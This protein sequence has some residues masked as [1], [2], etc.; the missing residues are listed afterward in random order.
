L[1]GLADLFAKYY[2]FEQGSVDFPVIRLH[3]A[4]ADLAC[5]ALHAR[6]FA[7]GADIYFADGAFA[8]HTRAG[9]WLLAHEVAHVVQQSAGVVSDPGSPSALS[10]APA[11]TPE[12][13]AAAAAANAFLAGRSFRFAAAKP[14]HGHVRRRVVQRYMAWE[15]A[16]LGDLTVD[17]IQALTSTQSQ[18]IEAYCALLETLGRH[19]RSV[20]EE[21]LQSRY[22]G[23]QTVRLPGSGLVVTLGELNILPDYLG[24]PGEIETAPAAFLGPLIQ[25]VRSWSI[26]ELRRSAG[27][28]RRYRRLP[29]GLR[30]PLLGR[31]AESAEV[32]AVDALGKRCGFA[33]T[34]RYSSVLARNAA[35]FAPF[36]WYRWHSFHLMARALIEKSAAADAE[37]RENLR[38]RARI[39]AG[40]AD[41]FLQ[42][43]FAAGHLINKTLMMQWY[44][45]WLGESGVWNPDRDMLAAMTVAR[46]PMLHGS[47][48]YDRRYARLT[49]AAA[50]RPGAGPWPP[51]DP[52]DVADA[53]TLPDS[54]EASGLIGGSGR[55]E[56]AAYAAY[57]TMLG[58]ATVQLGAKVAH[59][60]LNK[61]SLVVSSGPDGPRFRLY[62]DHRLLA[63][64]GGIWR[65]AM[66]AGASRRA[67][68]E[69]L[70]YG[71]TGVSSWEIFESFPDHVEA[72]GRLITLEDWHRHELRDLCFR[73][74]FGRWSTRATRVLI[75]GTFRQLGTPASS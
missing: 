5:R 39:M 70:Q 21:R 44:I 57:L 28:R 75:S 33:P 23:R 20:A 1:S 19:P 10:V 41:H 35:H 9:L 30:Y 26:A 15:H 25:S 52:Q 68:S 7:V 74:L 22:P 66:A 45:E 38:N 50:G 8:P 48:L 13:H 11:G 47:H 46:Q 73:N 56:R 18:S 69:L 60:Y 42:D 16:L 24:H 62:G 27:G 59:D 63:G 32:L 6:A 65:A 2:L 29:G 4:G 51:C 40:Y 12:E 37:G 43:S 3:Y 54:I 36:S 67:I 14:R 64:G 61:R 53:A 71:E 58:S 49:A 72:G 17:E 31:L 34:K 55:E